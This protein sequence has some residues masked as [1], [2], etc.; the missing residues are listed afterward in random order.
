[1]TGKTILG[2]GIAAVTI[3][4]AVLVLTRPKCEDSGGFLV[5]IPSGHHKGLTGLCEVDLTEAQ[6]AANRKAKRAADAVL[7]IHHTAVP[8]ERPW[9][10]QTLEIPPEGLPEYLYQGWKDWPKGGA[11][12]ITTPSGEVLHDK[13]GVKVNFG[14]QPNGVYTFRTDPVGSKREVQIYNRW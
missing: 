3:L 6:K 5:S 13:P 10:F 4:V 12:T 14:F 11:I 8:A 1:M 9:T 7:V 2:G